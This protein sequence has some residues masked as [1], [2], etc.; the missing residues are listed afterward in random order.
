M[1]SIAS[2]F[3]ALVFLLSLQLPSLARQVFNVKGGVG[4][5]G[6]AEYNAVRDILQRID[7]DVVAFQ[8][9]RT[10]DA[11]NWNALASELGYGSQA[12]GELTG[13]AGALRIG[14]FSRF[15]I[16]STFN[17]FSPQNC[18]PPTVVNDISRPPFRVVVDVPGA[19]KPLVLWA[20]HHK[21]LGGIENDFR[22]AVESVR[23]NDDIDDYLLAN[24][25]HTEYVV[26]GD[27]NDDIEESQSSEILSLPSGLPAS[28]Q[29]GCDITFPVPYAVF[30]EDA[31]E[32]AG[33]GMKM[34][35]A[36][37]ED[38]SDPGTLI[39]SG[40]RVDYV[41]VSSNLWSSLSWKPNGR[42]LQF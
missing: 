4:D 38:I 24:P 6:G 7:A 33:G 35:D 15:P 23:V 39:A 37:Q 19:E 2:R 25:S 20:L 14:Y 3:V 5:V 9:L 41:F 18:I 11:D 30:P 40:W 1:H 16:T 8:E 29:L 27:F 31:Y 12:L 21:S 10:S 17:V 34:L 22:R 28:Y 36:F 42:G 32:I 26:L 13:L